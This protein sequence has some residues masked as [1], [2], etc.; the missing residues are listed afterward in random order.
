[1]SELKEEHDENNIKK[2]TSAALNS[3]NAALNFTHFV[4]LKACRD[5]FRKS[6]KSRLNILVIS[7]LGLLVL[8]GIIVVILAASS[9][10]RNYFLNF[11][12]YFYNLGLV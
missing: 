3:L 6:R 7:F 5:C 4:G 8:A 2:K 9:K 11:N 1:M 10:N 12:H